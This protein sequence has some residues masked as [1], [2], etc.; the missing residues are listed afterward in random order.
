M[1]YQLHDI[2]HWPHVELRDAACQPGYGVAWNAEMTAL[3]ASDGPFT[4]AFDPAGI[5]ETPED[6]KQRAI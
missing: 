3:T 2:S 4:V 6:F 1:D 5:E